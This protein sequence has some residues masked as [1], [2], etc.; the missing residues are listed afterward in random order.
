MEWVI[1][2]MAII[3]VMMVIGFGILAYAMK[4]E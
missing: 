2:G 4:Q 1:T 3:G